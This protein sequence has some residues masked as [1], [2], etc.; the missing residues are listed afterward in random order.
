MFL[1]LKLT[2]GKGKSNKGEI[3]SAV[4]AGTSFALSDS[5]LFTAAHTVFNAKGTPCAEIGVVKAYED[6]VVVDDIVVLTYENH[7]SDKDEDWAVYKRSTGSFSH[8]V[9]VC[10]ENELPASGAQIGIR[11][12][13]VGLVTVGSVTNVTLESFHTKVSNYQVFVDSVPSTS[14][15]RKFGVT[16]VKPME[17]PRRAI[18]VVGGRVTGACGAAYFGPNGK[19][20]AFHVESVDDGR[21]EVSISHSY[22]SDRSHTSY[23]IGLVLCRLAKFKTWY[24]ERTNG[25][26]I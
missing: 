17:Q 9:Q 3:I 16:K 24:N 22:N 5:F 12:F 11:D 2:R 20:V 13:P 8:Y 6:P 26:L 21:D 18:Q 14:K 23:S 10:P 7:C 15:K 19:V 25:A 1:V 4:P